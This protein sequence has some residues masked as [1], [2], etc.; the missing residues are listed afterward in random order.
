MNN[1][2][3][4][5][6]AKYLDENEDRVQEFLSAFTLDDLFEQLKNRIK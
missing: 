4:E 3:V 1:I 2:T 5:Q 6:F